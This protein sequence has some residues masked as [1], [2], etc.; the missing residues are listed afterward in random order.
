MGVIDPNVTSLY[1]LYVL[2]TL[3][4]ETALIIDSVHISPLA[5]DASYDVIFWYNLLGNLHMP[6][7][8]RAC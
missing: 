3:G 4:L 8:G 1:I 2:D 7:S 5:L 6:P